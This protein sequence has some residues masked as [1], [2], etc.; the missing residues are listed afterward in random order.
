MS[1]LKLVTLLRLVM[2]VGVVRLVRS[3]ILARFTRLVSF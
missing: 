1:L 2:S 3:L